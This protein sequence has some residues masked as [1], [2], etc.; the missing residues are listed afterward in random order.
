MPRGYPTRRSLRRRGGRRRG[1]RRRRR[2]SCRA[3]R[4]RILRRGHLHL[5]VRAGSLVLAVDFTVEVV[6]VE[7]LDQLAVSVL[8][9]D[10]RL[11]VAVAIAAHARELAGAVVD[12]LHV[13]LAVEVAVALDLGLEPGLR[14][15]HRGHV[16]FAV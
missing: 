3:T 15:E 1:S 2:R 14:I 4:R 7:D 16:P 12:L 5:R 6:V 11:A 8:L 10:V 9:P 13:E